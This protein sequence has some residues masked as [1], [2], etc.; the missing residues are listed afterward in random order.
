MWA[1]ASLSGRPRDLWA[2]PDG[3]WGRALLSDEAIGTLAHAAL[4]DLL[5]ARR[6][7]TTHEAARATEALLPSGLAPT[8]RL[9]LRQRCAS[10]VSRY[11]RE[12]AR[13]A[14]WRF[15]GAEVQA[16][17]VRLDL[18]WT[19]PGGVIEADEIKTGS[20][21]ELRFAE[22]IRQA[23]AQVELGRGTFGPK[24]DAVRLL[25]L[26]RPDLSVRVASDGEITPVRRA[27]SC[28]RAT[29]S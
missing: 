19:G 27:A 7:L 11:Q 29:R 26:A 22:G 23:S 9:S 3:A 2:R 24:F 21:P 4:A 16:E 17:E 15:I 1:D 14:S 18:L 5:V 12:F 13:P 8:Y 10:A 28:G 6:P 20:S 25:L